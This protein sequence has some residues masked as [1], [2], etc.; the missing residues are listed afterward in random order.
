[1][2]LTPCPNHQSFGNVGLIPLVNAERALLSFCTTAQDQTRKDKSFPSP[3][4]PLEA[5]VS[6]CCARS[7]PDPAGA[8]FALPVAAITSAPLG[9][10]PALVHSFLLC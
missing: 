1:L 5:L 7:P 9:S 6:F 3:A 2:L 4:K 8:L 10:S